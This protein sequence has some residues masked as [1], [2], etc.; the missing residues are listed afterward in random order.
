MKQNKKTLAKAFVSIIMVMVMFSTFIMSVSAGSTAIYNS[1]GTVYNNAEMAHVALGSF[2]NRLTY[3]SDTST[4]GIYCESFPPSQLTGTA[5]I[6]Y[7]EMI[8]KNT[9]FPYGS[10]VVT[11]ASDGYQAI[12]E[13]SFDVT[14]KTIVYYV[15]FTNIIRNSTYYGSRSLTLYIKKQPVSSLLIPNITTYYPD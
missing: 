13:G 2:V 9:K 8:D 1:T 6:E 14:S 3:D 5:M 7:G 10:K 4:L 11:A 12:A 15:T